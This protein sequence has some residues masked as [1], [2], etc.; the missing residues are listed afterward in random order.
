MNSP[1]VFVQTVGVIAD[2]EVVR[3]E[4]APED[5]FVILASDG[6]WEFIP[7]QEAVDIVASEIEH[8]AE[9]ACQKLISTAAER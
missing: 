8:G 5:H 4:I 6:V 7:S 9:M 3:H 2:P 1:F